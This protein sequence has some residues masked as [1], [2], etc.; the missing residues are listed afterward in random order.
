[1]KPISYVFPLEKYIGWSRSWLEHYAPGLSKSAVDSVFESK[2]FRNKYSKKPSEKKTTDDIRAEASEDLVEYSDNLDAVVRSLHLPN[3]K[4][5][6]KKVLG[7]LPSAKD[8]YDI[9][10]SYRIFNT[11]GKSRLRRPIPLD[12]KL[13][14]IVS[15]NGNKNIKNKNKNNKNN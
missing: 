2:Y 5:V 7:E 12:V 1:M 15:P 14:I 6:I 10:L 13:Y 3:E 9:Q 8:L 4:I 11:V